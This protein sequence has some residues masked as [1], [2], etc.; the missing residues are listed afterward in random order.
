LAV[1]AATP[2]VAAAYAAAMDDADDAAPFEPDPR[3]VE[4]IRLHADIVGAIERPHPFPW[5]VV[6]RV[7]ARDGVLWFKA[8]IPPL[9]F[10]A[11]VVELLA[12]RGPDV[13]TELVAV[14]AERGWMLMRDAGIRLRDLPPARRDWERLLSLYG[15]LQLDVAPDVDALLAVGCPDRR[16]GLVPAE[17]AQLLEDTAGSLT[18]RERDLLRA[19]ARDVEGAATALGEIG[20]PETIQHDDFHDGNM[21]VRDGGFR[22]L[23]WGDACVSHPFATLRIPLELLADSTDWDLARLRDAYLE[24]F[25]ALASPSELRRAVAAAD[26]IAGVT[27]ALKW[28]PIVAA[29]EPP[30]RWEDAVPIRLRALLAA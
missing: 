13:V 20:I 2:A 8:N 23:D 18:T 1:G 25:S 22:V 30:H 4:W 10:E 29:L 11:G 26:A 27:T 16:S 9:A 14:D 17:F 28:A 6:L 3:H 15:Q 12:R 19:H 5:S 7:P 21:F 24:P